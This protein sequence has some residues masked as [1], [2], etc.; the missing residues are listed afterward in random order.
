MVAKISGRATLKYPFTRIKFNMKISLFKKNTSI[1]LESLREK[2]ISPG[3]DWLILICIFSA[4]LLVSAA[5][6]AILFYQTLN[7]DSFSLNIQT[8]SSTTSSS[9][10]TAKLQKAVDFIKSRS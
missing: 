9:I 6:S 10:D 7:E 1:S 5:F 8:P 4:I 2:T 3:K